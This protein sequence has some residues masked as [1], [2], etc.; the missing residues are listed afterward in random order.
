MP[1]TRPGPS[2]VAFC[3]IGTIDVGR[4][5]NGIDFIPISVLFSIN[6]VHTWNLVERPGDE[7]VDE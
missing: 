5:D 2:D 3:A 7:W 6:A 4:R 1:R